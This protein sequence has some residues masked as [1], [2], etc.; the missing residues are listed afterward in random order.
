MPQGFSHARSSGIVPGGVGREP[1]GDQAICNANEELAQRSAGLLAL[2]LSVAVEQRDAALRELASVQAQ[3]H[4]DRAALLN[5]QDAFVAT[6]AEDHQ[7]SFDELSC[8]LERTKDELNRLRAF[9]LKA[10]SIP[11]G[12][13]GALTPDHVAALSQIRRLQEQ[14]ESAYTEIDETR[15]DAVRLQGE[16]DDAVSTIDDMRVELVSQVEAARDEAFQLQTQLDEAHRLLEDAHDEALGL[17]D[18][19]EELRQALD[20]RDEELTV[21]RQQ[22]DAVSKRSA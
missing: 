3:A 17:K 10:R 20:R 8:E 2:P 4:A 12:G 9:T 1:S 6:L 16:R 14:L 13:E 22:L 15:A 5:E 18:E 7:R 19:L 21:L 11:P